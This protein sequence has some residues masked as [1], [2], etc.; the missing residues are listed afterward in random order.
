[1]S[2]WPHLDSVTILIFLSEQIV[3]DNVRIWTDFC[4]ESSR[5]LSHLSN[6]K[7]IGAFGLLE[8]EIWAKHWTMSGLQ[9]RFRL[10]RCCYDLDFQTVEMSLSLIWMFLAY[11]LAFQPYKPNWNPRS[12]SPDTTQWLNSVP[13]WTELASLF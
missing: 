2:G 1:L 7:R 10:L 11:V 3:I 5:K 4:H 8:L 13:V 6:K 12:T 9:D